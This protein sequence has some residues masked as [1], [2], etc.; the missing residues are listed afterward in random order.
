MTIQEA[1]L[2]S[3][4]PVYLDNKQFFSTLRE[5]LQQSA[6]L[7]NIESVVVPLSPIVLFYPCC[8]LR[9]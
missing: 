7:A 4:E 5:V 9:L 1:R 8:M 3:L 6:S 2:Y